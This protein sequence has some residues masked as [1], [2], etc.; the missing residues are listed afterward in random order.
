MYYKQ[1]T[2]KYSQCSLLHSKISIQTIRNSEFV[3][4]NKK[5][6]FISIFY[7]KARSSLMNPLYFLLASLIKLHF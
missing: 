2:S 6:N 4:K 5:L 1:I 3:V 7:F